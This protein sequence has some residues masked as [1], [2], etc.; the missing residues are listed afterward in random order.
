MEKV[1]V[2]ESPLTC[3]GAVDFE[4]LVS[5]HARFVFKI[6]Y[7]ILR[8]AEDAE[9]VVQET[10][11]RAYRS[12]EAAQVTH[13]RAWLARIS[14][15][16][17]VDRV[18]RRSRKQGRKESEYLLQCLPAAGPGAEESLLQGERLAL[19]GHLLDGLPRSLRESL[20]LSTVEG[21]SSAQIAEMLDIPESSVRNR[22]SR[23]RKHLKEKL[24]ALMEGGHGA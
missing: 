15:R 10:F 12:G 4:A 8:N 18:R 20:I 23:A 1:V 6:A 5:A 11:F 22:V 21:M 3:A 2:A 19:L 14:W 9:D 16:L 13:M 24:A 7:A 17:A